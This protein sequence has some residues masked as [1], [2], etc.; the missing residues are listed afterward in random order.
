M[1]QSALPNVAV[2][3]ICCLDGT[4]YSVVS[5]NDSLPYGV[6][7]NSFREGDILV[8]FGGNNDWN[9]NGGTPNMGATN[10]INAYSYIIGLA[11]GAGAKVICLTPPSC[12]AQGSA[13]QSD[14]NVAQSTVSSALTG[15]TLTN[16]PDLIIDTSTIKVSTNSVLTAAGAYANPFGINY[17]ASD[18]VH[19]LDPGYALLAPVIQIAV[20]E[21]IGFS[22]VLAMSDPRLPGVPWANSGVV[23]VSAG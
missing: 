5:G 8:M 9:G 18:G 13:T 7:L 17:F 2:E 10:C 20:Q 1:L 6:S 23:T 4:P 15:K 22:P 11:H 3:F 12:K 19:L 16:N 21:S 14:V